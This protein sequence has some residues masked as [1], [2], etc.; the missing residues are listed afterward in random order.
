MCLQ[1]ASGANVL[2]AFQVSKD[3]MSKFCNKADSL[4]Y[5]YTEEFENKAY[6]L[7]MQ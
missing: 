7:L 5:E 2:V 3:D 1:G 6:Q 4:G